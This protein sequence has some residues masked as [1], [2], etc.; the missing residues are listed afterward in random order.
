M[1]VDLFCYSSLAPKDA[2]EFLFELAHQ[3]EDLFRHKFLISAVREANAVHKEIALEHG[4]ATTRSVFL[5]GLNDKNAAALVLTV[6]SLVKDV[7]AASNVIVL[8]GNEIS[9]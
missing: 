1:A 4:L 7:F 6:A 5:I 9:L 8:H 3:H 2:E